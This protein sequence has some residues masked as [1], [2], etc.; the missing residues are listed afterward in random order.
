[1]AKNFATEYNKTGDS[2][3]LNQSVFVVLESTKGTFAPPTDTDFVFTLAGSSVTHTQPVTSSPHR[4]GRHNTDTF[5]EKKST[6]WE[7]PTFINIDTAQAGGDT[8]REPGMAVLWR[9]LLGNQTDTGGVSSVFESS[10]DPDITFS[11]Y[12]NGDVWSQQVRGS[13]TESMSLSA[14]GDGQA[15]CSWSG[16]GADRL[17]VGIG[18]TVANNDG[19]DTITL[20][21]VTEA[22]RFPVG[23][24]VMIVEGNGTTRSADTLNGTYKTVLETNPATG[25][26]RLSGGN[27][28][29]ADATTDPNGA[30]MF[31]AYAEPETPTGISNIQ[32]G[33]V[34]SIAIDGLG[35]TVACVRNFELTLNNNHERVNYCYGTDGLATPFFVAGDRLSVELTV[36]MNLN[37]STVEW[38][39]DLDQFTAQDI[40]FVLGDSTGRHL[41]IDLPKII[42]NIP[43]TT[44][45]ETGSIPFSADGVGYQTSLGSADEVTVSYL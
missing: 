6:E 44:L 38:L 3:S 24:Q 45:P 4:S 19:G 12:E 43:T 23:A 1:L 21:V 36:E 30:Q 29:D 39:Y 11:L 18:R 2:I 42:F 40:D 20:A 28:T 17:R 13:F 26:V 14:P 5:A 27:L 41:K 7:L 34:G 33:L 16:A 9:S 8:A 10:V 37:H 32:T 35:G 25:V 31:L 22:K 15:Q